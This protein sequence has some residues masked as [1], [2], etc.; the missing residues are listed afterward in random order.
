MH[1]SPML[2]T[3]LGPLTLENPFLLSSGPPTASAAQIIRAF[4]AGWG[5]AVI[6][7][8]RPDGMVIEDVSPRFAARK[9]PV[10]ELLGFENIELLTKEPVSYWTDQIPRMK[11]EF[12]GKILI[13]SIM[14]SPDPSDWVDLATRVEA[15]GADAVELNVSCPHGMPEQGVGA[16]IGQNPAMVYQLTSAVCG[17]VD[18]PVIVKL[19]PNVTDI[20]PVAR[21]AQAGGAA[22]IS[23]I[24]TIQCLTG[25]DIASFEPLPSVGGFTTY[26]GYSGPA[27]KPVGLRVV[28]QI[29]SAIDLP[30]IG[31]GGVNSWEDAVEY[32]LAGASAVQVCTAV[33]W[34]GAGIIREMNRGLDAYL[35]EKGMGSPDALKGLALPKITTHQALTRNTRVGPSVDPGRC[36][37]CGRCVIACRDGGYHALSLQNGTVVRDLSRCDGCSLCFHVCPEGAISLEKEM[38]IRDRDPRG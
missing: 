7:T 35:L 4:R 38:G 12:P 33:M 3:T 31:I 34:H 26:G 10:G 16:A 5:G 23:A 13:A 11:S 18:L 2:L 17:A 36:T 25:I 19:T 8:I 6:K 28:S 24:N 21:A 37:S 14:G 15:A 27:V 20:V 1:S 30:V 32:I 29:A 9:S 22:M